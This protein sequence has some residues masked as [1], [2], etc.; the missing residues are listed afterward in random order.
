M[1]TMTLRVTDY[2][3]QGENVNGF[4]SVYFRKNY[5]NLPKAAL[6]IAFAVFLMAISWKGSKGP[7]FDLAALIVCLSL[8]GLTF[9]VFIPLVTWI[10]TFCQLS[11]GKTAKIQRNIEIT[12]TEVTSST[13]LTRTTMTWAAVHDVRET[14]KTILLFTNKKCAFIIPKKAFASPE[15]AVH[16]FKFARSQ[17]LRTKTSA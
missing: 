9:F 10:L 2:R 16:F 12:D 11:M 13:K 6:A 14:R 17:W 4:L 1:S 15:D 3:I 7:H 8:S 5:M